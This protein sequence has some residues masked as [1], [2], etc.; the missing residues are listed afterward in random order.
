MIRKGLLE[1]AIVSLLCIVRVADGTGTLSIVG[2]NV[3]QQDPKTLGLTLVLAD[4]TWVESEAGNTNHY[5]T[6]KRGVYVQL[7][8]NLVILRNSDSSVRV[9]Q[10]NPLTPA[11]AKK[12]DK[13]NGQADET[14]TAFTWEIH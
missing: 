1:L 10:L 12:G 2:K 13:G 11:N 9:G 7:A 14:G 6:T 3:D 5:F 8:P 4:H